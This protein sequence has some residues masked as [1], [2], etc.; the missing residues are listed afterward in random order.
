MQQQDIKKWASTELSPIS[1]LSKYLKELIEKGFTIEQVIPDYNQF[2][3]IESAIVIVSK[4]KP[5]GEP[6]T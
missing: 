4:Y 3:R 5:E 2:N 1:E 6:F